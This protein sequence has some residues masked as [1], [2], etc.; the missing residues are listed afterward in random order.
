MVLPGVVLVEKVIPPLEQILEPSKTIE[1]RYRA[2]EFTVGNDE[3]FTG[4]LV[5]DEG[6]SLVL[7]TGPG[8]T[9]IKKFAKNDVKSRPQA[10]SLMPPGLLNLLSQEQILDLLAFIESA[11]RKNSAAFAK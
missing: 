11:G 9:M 1:P 8:E 5:K 10:S 3:P 6:E 4:F 2:Y 7:Q